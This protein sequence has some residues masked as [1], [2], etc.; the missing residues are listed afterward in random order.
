MAD[1][2]EIGFPEEWTEGGQCEKSMPDEEGKAA[3]LVW[4]AILCLPCPALK[5]TPTSQ[6]VVVLST[7][8]HMPYAENLRVLFQVKVTGS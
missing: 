6:R 2:E 8:T 7:K 5:N 4:V 1:G 3:G